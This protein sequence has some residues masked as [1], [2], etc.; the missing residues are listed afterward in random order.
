MHSEQTR[1][2]ILELASREGFPLVRFAPA[3][4]VLEARRAASERLREGALADMAWMTEEWI[5][6][7]TEPSQF[8]DGARTVIV[9]ALPCHSDDPETDAGGRSHGRIAR[10]ARGRDYHR[11]FEKKLRRIARAIR[12]ELG[13]DARAT[14]DYGPLLERP[15]A[16]IAGM[17]WLGKSTMLLV[18]GLGPWV[19]LGVI[20][21]TLELPPDQPLRKTCGSCTRCI[22]ACPTGALSP[23][24]NVLDARLCISY[25]TIENRGP[26]PRELRH[27]FGDWIFGC[28]DCLDACPVGARSHASHP[29]LVPAGVEEARPELSVLLKLDQ[30]A[31][32][33]RF[34]GRAII[35]AKRDGFLRNVC[36]ALGNTGHEQDVPALLDALNDTSG[37]VRGHAA[38]AVAHM[39]ARLGLRGASVADALISRQQ[40]ESDPFVLEEVEAALRALRA[41]ATARTAALPDRTI[42]AMARRNADLG[43]RRIAVIGCAGSGKSTLARELGQ[44]LGL[45]VIHL[46]RLYWRPGWE[47]TP[48][49][50][51]REIVRQATAQDQWVIDGNYSSTMDLRLARADTVVFLDFP[52]AVC[53]W[54][55]LK[56]WA[57]QRGRQ[58]EDVGEGCPEKVDLE[59]LKW[60]WG[61]RKRSRP[62]T[63]RML[64][65]KKDGQVFVLRNAE[66]VAHFLALTAPRERRE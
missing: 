20:A 59:F 7:S 2:R 26:I 53:T 34:R 31:F 33:A 10:Y 40:V 64:S 56:R 12:E 14:V 3:A 54:R 39:A 11:V 41:T 21:T 38:W 55:V 60:I 35:R 17:G 16:A 18:P 42:T 65:E 30:E 44:R 37:L 19:L 57:S 62:G 48:P 5:E 29:D 63:L 9:F 8:L 13:A 22:V 28:D 43:M 23:D 6:R 52:T 61:Y 36:I 58:R 4:A 24:G 46:D 1:E 25:H 66:E 51:W 50:E 27:L 49:D 32:E 15:Y 45:P 47:A